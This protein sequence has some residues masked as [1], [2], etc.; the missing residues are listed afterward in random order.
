MDHIQS[1]IASFKNQ[2]SSAFEEYVRNKQQTIEVNF[3]RKC[4]V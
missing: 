2:L 3:F 4:M 1:L